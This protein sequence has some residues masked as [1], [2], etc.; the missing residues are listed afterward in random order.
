M[1]IKEEEKRFFE[2]VLGLDEEIKKQI[3][4]FET[5]IY[6]LYDLKKYARLFTGLT[7]KLRKDYEN[8]Q[9]NNSEEPKIKA[10]IQIHIKELLK[11]IE[12][13]ENFISKNYNSLAPKELA[14]KIDQEEEMI[15]GWI[16]QKQEEI[17]TLR[18]NYLLK[19]SQ[20]KI[21]E[22][23]KHINEEI[24]HEA[25]DITLDKKLQEVLT[26]FEKIIRNQ[27]NQLKG[28]YNKLEELKD[29]L[30]NFE[31]DSLD[32]IIRYANEIIA[33]IQELEREVRTEKRRVINPMYKLLRQKRREIRIINRLKNKKTK[34]TRDDI[35]RDI[36]TF[37]QSSETN[38]YLNSLRTLY[39]KDPNIFEDRA[40]NYINNISRLAQSAQEKENKNALKYQQMAYYDGL[41]QI[42]NKRA[43]E[44]EISH[45][46][47]DMGSL[48]MVDI[49]KFKGFNDYYGHDNGDVVLEFV[50][51]VLSDI[52]GKE[53]IYR[54]GGEEFTILLPNKTKEEAAIIL[55]KAKES[56]KRESRKILK[57]INETKEK[58]GESVLEEH[59]KSNITISIGVAEYPKETDNFE[60]LKRKADAR[61][62]ISKE[63]G[64]DMVTIEP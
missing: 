64:R 1:D 17:K 22:L 51:K 62:Y 55:K 14:E 27:K 8:L 46:L 44:Q 31:T 36:S 61:L 30:I 47:G 13:I 45:F 11:K 32:V 2:I 57:E 10:N 12:E 33:L 24:A 15:S 48:A 41:T 59:R 52:I 40:V 58:R 38:Y 39:I 4:N 49:D 28:I 54:F 6:S 5:R 42:K 53:Y 60:E 63:K 23:I 20:K 19:D 3:E 21:S 18:S 25:S 16:T 34:I 26:D 37:T 35:T 29:Y 43:L 56:L 9:N 50:A 7:T